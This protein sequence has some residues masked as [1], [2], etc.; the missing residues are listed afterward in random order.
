MEDSE[1]IHFFKI[2]QFVKNSEYFESSLI[3]IILH[4][5]VIG[6]SSDFAAFSVS[7]AISANSTSIV[8][9]ESLYRIHITENQRKSI[10][11]IFE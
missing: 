5:H 4:H 10:K 6:S 8:E 3:H 9:L 11:N 1:T 2:L 7:L